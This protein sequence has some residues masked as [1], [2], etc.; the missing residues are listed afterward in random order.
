M[1]HEL[2]MCKCHPQPSRLLTPAK[3][4]LSQKSDSKACDFSGKGETKTA[5]STTGDC[6]TLLKEAG[7]LAGT[8]TV[9][10]NPN[11]KSGSGKSAANGLSASVFVVIT[12]AF[13]SGL[14]AVL[15]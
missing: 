14:A 15:V 3:Y 11:A 1:G 9:T 2:G 10:S 5:T 13:F 6:A 7:G 4:Y 12:A 8:S